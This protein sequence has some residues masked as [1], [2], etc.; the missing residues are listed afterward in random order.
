MSLGPVEP[1]VGRDR[2]SVTVLI[3]GS[4]LI[5]Y[6]ASNP[7]PTKTESPTPVIHRHGIQSS[8][9]DVLKPLLRSEGT[10]GY[11]RLLSHDCIAESIMMTV[12]IES[13]YACDH[14]STIVERSQP[15]GSND[16]SYQESELRIS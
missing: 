13:E 15:F 8:S 10:D 16:V 14:S 7:F 2:L 5:Q 12:G 1:N 6:S 9:S 11:I 4:A 3:P